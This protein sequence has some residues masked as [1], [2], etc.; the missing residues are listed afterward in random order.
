[1]A[2]VGGVG[3]VYGP[4][5][6]AFVMVAVGEFFRSGFFGLL[7][8]IGKKTGSPAVLNVLEVVTHS[9][10]LV[11]GVLVVVVILFLPNGIVGDWVKIK[12]KVFRIKPT[13]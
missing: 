2:I 8:L 3:T 1:V 10:V 7:G 9:H 13:E 4:A 11:F 12:R 5:V 6:G